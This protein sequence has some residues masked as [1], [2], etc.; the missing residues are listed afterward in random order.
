M[1]AAATEKD[2]ELSLFARWLK[3]S[4]LPLNSNELAQYDPI[5]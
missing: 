3:E 1:I 2:Q 4:L 5:T